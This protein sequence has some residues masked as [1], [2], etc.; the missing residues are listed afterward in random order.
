MPIAFIPTRH[1]AM[2]ESML[3]QERIKSSVN[4]L[5]Y[6]KISS[7]NPEFGLRCGLRR[8]DAVVRFADLEI[9]FRQGG[10]MD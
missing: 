8:D 10:V 2:Q 4:T 1:T 5:F 6:L 3:I 9:I 7:G